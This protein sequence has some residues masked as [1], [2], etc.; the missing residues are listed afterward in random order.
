M[1]KFAFIF[2]ILLGHFSLQAQTNS[3][4]AIPLVLNGI[5]YNA[6]GKLYLTKTAQA[7][8]EIDRKDHY[9]FSQ[10]QA[11][12]MGTETGILIDINKPAFNGTVAYGPFNEMAAYPTIA[13]LPKDAKMKQGKALLEIKK[14]FTKANDFFKYEEKG[15]GVL[16]YRIMDSSGRIIYEGRV[17]FEGKGPYMVQPTIVEG[18]MINILQSNGCVISFETQ[19]AEMTT[20]Q[21]DDKI[22]ADKSAAKHHEIMVD[23]LM[24]ATVYEY[25]IRYG[26]RQDKNHFKTAP[27][28][29]S[30]MPFTFAFASANRATTGGGERDFGGV[31]YQTSRAIMA[32]AMMNHSVFMHAQGDITTG[33]NPTEDGHLMEYS[34]FK[35]AFE[36]FWRQVPV[37]VGFGDHEPNKKVFTADSIT[38]KTKNI[39]QFPYATNSGEASFAKAFVHPLNGPESEDGASYDPQPNKADFPTYKENVYFYTYDNVA[40]VV[41]NTEYWES[42]DPTLTSGCPEGYIMDQQMKWLKETMFQL[43]KNAAI[44]HIFVVV[45]DAVFPNGDHLPDAMW[46]NGD[47][48]NR[49]WV[50]GK[51]LAKG[52][53]ERRDEILDICVNQSKK[54]LSFI[55]GDE[56]NFSM[57]KVTPQTS[58]YV[59]NYAGTKWTLSRPFYNINNGAG[60]SAPYAQLPSPW[61]KDFQFFS[62]P[63]IVA[64]ISVNGQSVTLKALNVETFETVCA[65]VQLR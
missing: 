45:H 12:P 48:K 10:M 16:G 40:M 28:E 42:K 55:S 36:P 7:L 57:L 11:A 39:E 20:L 31:N 56:H 4:P 58:I 51:P 19:A 15:K 43:E 37:Y 46:W 3:L 13:F 47:N 64:L 21:I 53:I 17:A 30:R 1:K 33:G 65:D 25:T 50:A 35:R 32:A 9:T 63:P 23:D 24:P 52:T 22:Y 44:D 2:S 61:S 49:A 60:G 62:A 6:N 8:E 54:F 29:G 5:Q 34:N 41:L 26:N 18:P 59:D 27:T 38:K 14:I